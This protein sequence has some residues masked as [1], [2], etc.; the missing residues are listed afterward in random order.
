MTKRRILTSLEEN[1]RPTDY[2]EY[3]LLTSLMAVCTILAFH[4]L[5]QP[6]GAIFKA[7]ELLLTRAT[8]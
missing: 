7:T 6:F 2:V 5:V 3:A 1:E 4:T 8:T